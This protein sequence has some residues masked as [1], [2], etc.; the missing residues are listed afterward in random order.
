MEKTPLVNI[1]ALYARRGF[2]NLE[3]TLHTPSKLRLMYVLLMLV[4]TH[5]HTSHQEGPPQIII[6]NPCG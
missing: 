5:L 2:R 6:V 4:R 3:K 1:F